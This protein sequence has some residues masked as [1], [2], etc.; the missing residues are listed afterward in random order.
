VAICFI[1]VALY[2][3]RAVP[4]EVRLRDLERTVK[5]YRQEVQHINQYGQNENPFTNR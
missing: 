2:A 5:T 4:D 1:I 3:Y